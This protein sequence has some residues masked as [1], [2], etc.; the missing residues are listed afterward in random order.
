MNCSKARKI[1]SLVLDGEAT[2]Q[3]KRLLDF[4]LMG[5]SSCRRALEMSRDIAR[6]ARSLPAPVP[7]EDLETQVRQML[8][9]GSDRHRPASRRLSA[10]L[11]IPAAAAILILAITLLPLSGPGDSM[12][13]NSMAGI[14]SYQAKSF[15][16]HLSASKAGVRTVPL[17][18]YTRQASLISF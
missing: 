15:G 17:S 3:Q 12:G 16:M 10:M 2:M 14:S 1:I 6:V 11:T 8:D 7:P 5:C 18:E 9:G 4:H 13:D